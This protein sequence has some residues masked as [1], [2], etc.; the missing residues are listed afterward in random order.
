MEWNKGSRNNQ[1]MYRCLFVTLYIREEKTNFSINGT[2]S[3][4][5]QHEEIMKIGPYLP[6]CTKIKSRRTIDL[7]IKEKM[8]KLLENNKQKWLHDL[9]QGKTFN[10]TQKT[11]TVKVKT[12]KLNYIKTKNNN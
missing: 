8:I 1:Y 4:W 10:R 6:Q 12:K 7:T 2:G 11:L 9:G 3:I 5:Y